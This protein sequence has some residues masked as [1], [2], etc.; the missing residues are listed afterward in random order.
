MDMAAVLV[1]N[2]VA[3]A[4]AKLPEEVKRQGVTTKKKSTAILQFISLY[5]PNSSFDGLALSNYALI[6]VRDELSRINGV[7]EVTI[8]GAG[9]YAMRIWL[10]PEAMRARSLTSADVVSAIREQN[11]Q[12]AAGQ[13]GQPPAP[14]GTAFQYTIKTLG[15]LS[16]KS[17][18]ENLIIKTADDGRITRVKDVS[19]VEL[20]AK[21]YKYTSV[22]NGKPSASIAIYQLP[23]ANALDVA[24]SV[25]AKLAQLSESFPDDLEYA[26][27][28]DTTA[29]VA[30]RWSRNT[31]TSG[32][33]STCSTIAG[34]MSR[35]RTPT[36][37]ASHA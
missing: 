9:D 13:V 36:P 34:P 3:I 8:F 6:N 18:F 15:R 20:G 25:E 16:D 12:V 1:Q 33:T 5:S 10:N 24:A 32:A 23:G 27:P 4:M 22:F 14:D 11:V 29:F 28:F 26:I 21:D 37:T 2:R 31:P 7:G 35:I 19:R 17:E 30:P